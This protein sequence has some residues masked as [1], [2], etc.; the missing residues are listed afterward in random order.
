MNVGT[1]TKRLVRRS[2]AKAAIVML[3]VI[4][5]A[6][7]V[8]VTSAQVSGASGSCN[9]LSITSAASATATA[10]T[11]FAF[12]VTT[13]SD[14]A[15]I[16]AAHLPTGL[17]LT[18]N[19]DGTASI[20]GTPG[21]KDNGLYTS[22][23][24]ATVTG[25]TA[26]T[27]ALVFTVD[28]SPSFTV[29]ATYLAKTG[30]AMTYPITTKYGYPVPTIRTASELPTGISLTD[31]GNGTAVLGGTPGPSSGGVYPITITV[32]TGLTSKQATITM[33]VH[34]APVIT[35]VDTDTA[36]VG[37]SMT[38]FGLTASGF[39]APVFKA[40]GLP[41]GVTVVSGELQG[42]PKT[43]GTYS[44]TISAKSSAGTS[45]QAFTFYVTSATSSLGLNQPTAIANDD[46]SLWITN[47]GDNTVTKTT[48]S[49]ALEATLSGSGFALNDPVAAAGNGSDL[50]VV[51]ASGSV[52]EINEQTDAV[53][54]VIQGASYA[55]NDP[56]ALL[57]DGGNVWVTNAGG[58]SVT[59]F[60][61][62]TGSLVQVLSN[63]SNSSY[64]FDHPVALA[65]VGANI[66]IVNSAGASV[67]DPLAG[68]ATVVN[69]TTGAF[70]QEVKGSSDGLE[71]PAGVAY[72]NGD[73]WITD[74]GSYQITELTS[75]GTLIQVITNSSND[76]NYGF[77]NPTAIVT[78]GNDVYVDSPPGS[79]PMITEVN[80]LNAEGDW[81]ECNT[82]TPDPDFDNPT[83]LVINGSDAWVVS[84]ADNTLTELNLS[85]GGEAI[86]WFQ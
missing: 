57:L 13:C 83:G 32:N 24:T 12:T 59:E 15:I 35:S 46:G 70:V 21:S 44:A 49:G 30:T 71:S 75:T 52:T 76:A 73:V 34:Q 64:A 11:S 20:T 53:V 63:A 47:V 37:T 2:P 3:V 22:T 18:G 51:N 80:A 16:K 72:D 81:Y 25:E 42:T 48:T 84:P 65:A 10:G 43:V 19:G 85:A 28:D 77:D 7:S 4:A 8:F 50:F 17:R 78:S 40:T 9:P 62:S 60:S 29:K 61:A 27:Q 23:V 79:S 5:G 55:F 36:N 39:P 41:S 67:S 68:S 82:N 1:R 66:W 31:N 74:G 54:Q 14:T 45:T 38:A 69:G 86:N 26:A 33:T 58:S 6:S 56:S